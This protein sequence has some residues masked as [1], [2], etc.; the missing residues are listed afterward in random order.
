MVEREDSKQHWDWLQKEE[1]KVDIA[2]VAA[3]EAV[4]AELDV[5]DLDYIE[6]EI[7]VAVER[8]A[9]VAVVAAARRVQM[10]GERRQEE[11]LEAAEVAAAVAEAVCKQ[12]RSRF[13]PWQANRDSSC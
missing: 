9:A 7:V 10:V 5:E 1:Q 6:A 4:A 8:K 12:D 3:V 13:R 11:R 2:V